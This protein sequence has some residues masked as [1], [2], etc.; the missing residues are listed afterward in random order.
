MALP[1]DISAENI[2]QDKIV[3][4]DFTKNYY[5]FEDGDID[6]SNNYWGWQTLLDNGQKIAAQEGEGFDFIFSN[7][8]SNVNF[9]GNDQSYIGQL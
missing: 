7:V 8:P 3:A 4:Y 1:I 9:D 5:N 2:D 6:P